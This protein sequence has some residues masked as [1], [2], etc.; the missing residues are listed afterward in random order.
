MKK[1]VYRDR[2][3]GRFVSKERWQRSVAEAA[4]YQAGKPKH[5][6]QTVN[7]VTSGRRSRVKKIIIAPQV[8]ANKFYGE[9][10]DVPVERVGQT[11]SDTTIQSLADYNDIMDDYEGLYDDMEADGGADYAGPEES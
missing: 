3:T 4:R 8:G 5:V 1:T 11:T 9:M 2:T 10:P 7:V 6:R